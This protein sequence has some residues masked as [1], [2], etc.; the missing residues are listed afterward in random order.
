MALRLN[1]G[2]NAIENTVSA[3]KDEANGV[4]TTGRATNKMKFVDIGANLLD[5]MFVGV[6][7]DKHRHEADLDDVIE[8]SWSNGI[9]RM[10]VTAGT[11]DEA[12]RALDLARND[13]RTFSTVGVHPTRC[14][15]LGETDEN[16]QEYVE[17]LRAVVKDGMSDGTVAALGELG[18][19]YARTQFCDKD[20]QKRGFLAQL[21]IAE[22]T[23]L[24]LF[25]HNRD[26]GTDLLDL[27][28]ENR[29][30]FSRGV[31]HSFDDTADLAEKFIDLDLYIGIN[32]CSLKTQENLNAV[33]AIP[34]ERILLET[35]CPWC[36]VRA[37]HAGSG[38]VETTF[39]TKK[40]K[41]FEP[42][43]CI[44]NRF[45]PCHIIQIAE[46]VAGV[47]DI[48]VE[49]VAEVT[50]KNAYAVFGFEKKKV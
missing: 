35:D 38:F 45:E 50:T 20:T 39:P 1:G 8:R 34:L 47:K 44:K 16:V 22:D 41:Q 32:G 23:G 2:T 40:E 11:L 24:P 27:L 10:L 46:I 14:N 29:S 37:T 30:R 31:V 43:C 36:D 21:N 13:T 7:R 25:L 18:L 19:D 4:D 42:G 15:E 12:Q 9:D 3:Q 28:R 33:K 6:Y 49:E 26:T 17:K 48:S 5:P